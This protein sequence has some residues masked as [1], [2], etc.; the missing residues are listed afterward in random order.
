[1]AIA[2]L[3]ILLVTYQGFNNT[4]NLLI[5]LL[6]LI[7]FVMWGVIVVIVLSLGFGT[8]YLM[9]GSLGLE[10]Q[11]ETFA[12][13]LTGRH[14]WATY[15]SLWKPAVLA[16]IG[17]QIGSL[18]TPLSNISLL[19]EL[20]GSDQGLMFLLA[21]ALQTIGLTFGLWLWLVYVRY[22]AR[23]TIGAHT[24]LSAPHRLRRLM[25]LISTGLLFGLYLPI[26]LGNLITSE[27]THQAT[28][29]GILNYDIYIDALP[30]AILGGLFLYT[31][32]FGS[33]WLF[34]QSR[35]L[36]A[37]ARCPA[38][39]QITRQHYSVGQS[40]EHCGHALAPWLFVKP[41]TVQQPLVLD[42]ATAS[43]AR[44]FG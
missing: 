34:L 41:K 1:M 30:I 21:F 27:I 40:C 39:R 2:Q 16:A 3:G 44:E 8:F 24:G 20:A 43:P 15:L 29:G 28:S 11:R 5:F 18:T 22:F 31:I 23:R 14:G 7:F 35:R 25:T 13:M 32:T 9:V 37:Q 19:P 38:C 6:V 17:F 10:V 36:F 4:P 12:H 33:T 26:T 42:V